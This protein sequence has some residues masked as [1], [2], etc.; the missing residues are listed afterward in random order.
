MAGAFTFALR[1]AG[2]DDAELLW[3]AFLAGRPTSHTTLPEALLRNQHRARE[4]AYAAGYPGIENCVIVTAGRPVG[5][6]LVWWSDDE[7][8][9]D[10]L[11][12]L[13]A[14]RRLFSRFAWDPTLGSWLVVVDDVRVRGG[15][16]PVP[17]TGYRWPRSAVEGFARCGIT[18]RVLDPCARAFFRSSQMWVGGAGSRHDRG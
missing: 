5:R 8:R 7:C 18:P 9:V 1:M 6:L 12:I 11:V 3:Q 16:D 4:A 10:D 2:P 14:E 13:P 17:M 15:P